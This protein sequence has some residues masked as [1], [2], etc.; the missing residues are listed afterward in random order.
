MRIRTVLGAIALA[1]A[2]QLPGGV[3]YR[4]LALPPHDTMTP[5]MLREVSRLVEAGATVSCERPP[6]RSPSL[7]GYPAVDA[8]LAREAARVWQRGVLRLSPAAAI[9]AL[10]LQPDVACANAAVMEKLAWQH[11]C[12]GAA[13]WYFVA[14]DNPYAPLSAEC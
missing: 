5:A 14:C 6:V 9:E 3:R 13:D 7:A 2:G 8:A 1:I 4:F 12:A 10:G 11:R